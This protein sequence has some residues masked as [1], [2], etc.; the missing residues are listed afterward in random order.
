VRE[1]GFDTLPEEERTPLLAGLARRA[2]PHWGL[3]GDCRLRLVNLSEN[4]TFRVTDRAGGGGRALRLHRDGYSTDAAIRSELAWLTALRDDGVVLTPRPVPGTDGAFLQHIA[5]PGRERPVRAVL[6][7]WEAGREPGIGEDLAGPMATLGA[8]AARMH[9]HARRWPLPRGFE[10]RT[11]DWETALG[12][13]PHWGRW[14]DGLAVTPERRALF[15]AASGLVRERLA[16]FGRGPERFGLCHCDLR[17]ANLLVD[18]ARVKVLDFDDSGFSW[19]LYDAATPI[20][21]HE[22]RPEA[23][24]LVRAWV[25]GYREAGELTAAEE[26]EIPT[27]VLFRRLLLVAWIGSHR[28]TALARSL[29]AGYTEGTEALCRDYLRRCG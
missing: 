27:F 13:S 6:F 25:A 28:A 21:F 2:L 1:G 18:G 10:R 5:W 19:F 26:A 4:A 16:A 14:T 7:G 20:S 15:G 29:G 17:L 3:P 12:P 11:W 24:D 22:H 8:I 23:A 9:A